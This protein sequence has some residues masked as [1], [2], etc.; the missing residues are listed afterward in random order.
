MNP[1]ELYATLNRELE[2]IKEAKTFKYEVP[3]ESEQGGEVMV[4]GHKV[5]MLA[6]NN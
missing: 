6:S 3:L 5:V 4:E 1:S 2:N